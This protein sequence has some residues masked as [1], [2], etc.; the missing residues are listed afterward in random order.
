MV[1]LTKLQK[2]L[3]FYFIV[4]LLKNPFSIPTNKHP[5]L[6]EYL[7]GIL[8]S[9]SKHLNCHCGFVCGI[10]LIKS[11]RLT[12]SFALTTYFIENVAAFGLL[13]EA[14]VRLGAHTQTPRHVLLFYFFLIAPCHCRCYLIFYGIRSF[15]PEYQSVCVLAIYILDSARQ[16][17]I[18]RS[19]YYFSMPNA[20]AFL[21]K[22][23]SSYPMCVCAFFFVLMPPTHMWH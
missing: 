22:E 19:S 20:F 8:R 17:D 6:S 3:V 14:N 15:V 2:L 23:A 1:A 7:A 18:F 11:F 4:C 5:L 10:S 12:L 13:S 21:Y 16:K 9:V